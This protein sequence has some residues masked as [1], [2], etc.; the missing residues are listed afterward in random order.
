MNDNRIKIMEEFP[1]PKAIITMSLPAIIGLIVQAIY[2][3]VDT[4]FVSW[5]GPLATGATQVV[6]PLTMI[7]SAIGLT[8]GIGGGAYISRLLGNKNYSEANRTC[9]TSFFISLIAGIISSILSV[10]FLNNLLKL[11]GASNSLLSNASQYGLFIAIG[12]FAQISNMT[13]NNLLRGEGSAKYSMIGMALGAL[14]NIILDPIL[15]FQF[16]LGIK[17]AAIA[18]SIS[19]IFTFSILLTHY[20]KH[21]TILSIKIKDITL[22]ASIFS[23]IFKVGLPTFFRQILMSFSIALLNT[24]A[25]QYSGDSAIAAIGIVTR[26]LMLS[27]FILFGLGQGFQPIAGYNYG[28]KNKERLKQATKFSILLSLAIAIISCAV[29]LMFENTIL[30]IFKPTEN[31]LNLAKYFS[32]YYLISILLMSITNIISVFYQSIGKGKEAFVLSISRQ[33]IFFIPLIIFLPQIVDFHGVVLSQPLADLFTFVLS[34]ILFYKTYKT[35][36]TI[37]LN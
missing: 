29:Y 35:Q 21:K 7:F 33:G 2:N 9:S 24:A 23:E 5:L 37:Y 18:T 20:L 3:I 17:G 36:N 6:Y 31:V 13:L 34:I 28:S 8:F 19:Q 10:I 30:G 12:G 11:F 1:I 27:F 16:D 26:V 15:I 32:K 25:G 14:L 4:M 22:K